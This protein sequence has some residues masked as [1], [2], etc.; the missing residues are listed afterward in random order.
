MAGGGGVSRSAS[1]AVAEAVEEGQELAGQAGRERRADRDVLVK[2]WRASSVLCVC[3]CVC[4]L[5][6]YS[7]VAR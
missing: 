5:G 7:F 2:V 3:V 4:V 1:A 6:L